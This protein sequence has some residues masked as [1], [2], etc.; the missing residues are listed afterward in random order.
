[1]VEVEIEPD[2]EV[3]AAEKK[4]KND[5][6][7]GSLEVVRWE[8]F[9]PRM[10]LRVLLVEADD[11]TRQI[12]AALLRKCSY[13]V[14][15]VS[16][17]L[18]AW[19]TLKDRPH[20][21]DLILTEV[22]LPSMSGYALLTLVMEHDICKNIPVIMMSSEDSFSMVLK[23]MLKGAADFLI[24]PVRRNEL[25]NLWHH[26]WRRQML[27]GGCS[28]HNLTATEHKVEAAAENNAVSNQSTDDG[29][30]T[31]KIKEKSA[32]QVLSQWKCTSSNHSDTGRVQLGN[33]VKLGQESF[34][35]MGQAEGI[36][37]KLFSTENS[38]R[39]VKEVA[40]C[41][42]TG[43]SIA[44][45]LE[46]NS[47][48]FE[49]ITHDTVG[50]ESEGGSGYFSAR[51][52]CNNKLMESPTGAIDLI[53]S[54]DKHPRSNFSI[55]DGGDKSECSPQLELSLRR[56]CLVSTKNQGSSEKHVLNHSD[57]SAFSWYKN[58]KSLQPIFPALDGNHAALKVDDSKP[59]RDLESNNSISQPHVVT[60]SDSWENLPS[61]VKGQSDITYS[62]TPPGVFS[63]TGVRRDDMHAGCNNILPHFYRTQSGLPSSCSPKHAA[64]QEY[65]PI[66][67]STSVHSDPDFHDS[68]QGYHWSDETTNSSVV[69]T[70]QGQEKQ[71]PVEEL[72]C[73]SLIDDQSACSHLCNDV[74]DNEK[75]SAH[76]VMSW[77]NASTRAAIAAAIDKT[78]EISNSSNR[79]V[80]DGLKGMDTHHTSQREAALTKFRLKRKD[81]C[82]EKKVRYQNRKRLAEQRSRVKGQFVKCNMTP[83]PL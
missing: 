16:D 24:K 68:E 58:R 57:A 26:V 70:V 14:A 33:V 64:K 35:N 59:I 5:E 66:P 47:A 21:I 3:G 9:L 19:E 4:K 17:G 6:K 80:H 37:G 67:V 65:A 61:S 39:F 36:S 41:S 12:I 2:V 15:A 8:R 79:F 13:R 40:H 81:R 74:S 53:A 7:D 48:F 32:T 27:V 76:G 69:Q 20:N 49:G 42:D 71:E 54:F 72:R 38:K 45:K 77:G 62:N 83:T 50:L 30:S 75:S 78:T 63:V 29:S 43:E 60:T 44:S 28:P 55:S 82:F 1:M 56:S 22:E 10:V 73:S 25:R 46:E 51:V 18:M 52:G 34:E 31:K 23:F 11:S